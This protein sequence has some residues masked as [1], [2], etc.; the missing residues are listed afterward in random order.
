MIFV[1]FI[2]MLFF[3]WFFS[4]GVS[5]LSIGPDIIF[6]YVFWVNYYFSPCLSLTFSFFCGIYADFYYTLPFGT[7]ALAFSLMSFVINSVRKNIEIDSFLPR[8]V[9]F[10]I[11]NYSIVVFLIFLNFIMTQNFNFDFRLMVQPI[12]NI[13]F[14]ELFNKL[15]LFVFKRRKDYVRI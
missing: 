2:S 15:F 8:I 7:H 10:I 9:N 5:I 13:I 12:L 14:F 4:Y 11:S 1:F 3:H 6:I